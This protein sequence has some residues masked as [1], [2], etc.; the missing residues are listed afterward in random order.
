MERADVEA[1]WK[2]END[3]ENKTPVFV[4]ATESCDTKSQVANINHNLV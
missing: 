1:V 3:R 2:A 4:Q